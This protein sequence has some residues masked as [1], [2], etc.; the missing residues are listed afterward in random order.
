M[1]CGWPACRNSL[2][3]DLAVGFKNEAGNSLKVKANLRNLRSLRN[4]RINTTDAKQSLRA[5]RGRQFFHRVMP[6][7]EVFFIEFYDSGTNPSRNPTF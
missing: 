5:I 2:K 3:F 6:E 1:N 7:L 4:V